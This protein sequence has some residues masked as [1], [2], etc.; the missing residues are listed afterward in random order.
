MNG[1]F[2]K[3]FYDSRP[4]EGRRVVVTRPR[5]QSE[6]IATLLEKLGSEVIHCPTIEIRGPDSWDDLDGALDRLES[7]DWIV[8]TSAN[9]ADFFFRRLS[10][11]RAEALSALNRTV[12]CAIGPATARAVASAGARVDLVAG[13]SKAEG[14]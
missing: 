4:L 10:E 1:D 14:A 9:G 13:D 3:N 6:E 2:G 12:V 5:G 7:Y 8:F 11:K